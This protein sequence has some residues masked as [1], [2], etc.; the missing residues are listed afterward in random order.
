MVCLKL[1]GWRC[2]PKQQSQEKNPR[3]TTTESAGKEGN[4]R[5]KNQRGK[6]L[7]KTTKHKCKLTDKMNS[8]TGEGAEVSVTNPLQTIKE[9][10]LLQ[11]PKNIYIYIKLSQKN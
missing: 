3:D 8:I 7:K 6:E 2:D 5:R 11:P 10:K 1:C 9:A 4:H